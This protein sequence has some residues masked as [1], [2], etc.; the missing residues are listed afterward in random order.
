MKQLLKK[1][2]ALSL[3]MM[4][5]ACNQAT[6]MTTTTETTSSDS[7][8]YKIGTNFELTGSLGDYGTAEQRG[9]EL[10]VK[11]ANEKAG[12]EKFQLVSYDNKSDQTES[13]TI[14]TQ[15][16]SSDVVGVVGPASSL[17]SAVTYPILNSA[18]KIVVSPSAT[19][20]N[21]TR[22]NPSDPT[23]PVYPY[24]FRISFEDS[25]QGAAMAQYAVDT[26]GVKKAVVL[27]DTSLDY[28]KGLSES[29]RTQ[30]TKLGGE[31]VSTQ[32]FVSGDTDFSSILT[33]IKSQSY[34]TLFIA[35]YYTEAALIIKQAREMGIDAVIL[36]GDGFDSE[37]LVNL[38]GS[39]NL[40]KVY[41][42]TAYTT[43]DASEKL[44]SFIQAYK[45]AYHEEPGM[46]AALAY[47]SANLLIE[48][49]TTTNSTDA[50]VL[51]E[52]LEKISFSG[53]TGD[54][55]FDETHTPIKTVLVV[56]LVDGVQS[57]V[58]SVI[59]Q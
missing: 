39:Q 7:V 9:V 59:P 13:V 53:I 33:T 4:L 42:T 12:Y 18:Q 45:D 16:A 22:E 20:N 31:V 25:Y 3:A 30:L 6:K 54:F 48:A 52:T 14:S 10:A 26:L 36:G 32:Y 1:G 27:E 11:Q 24:T 47:D 55:T 35:G 43:V 58:V 44:Q 21:V 34:D 46:F 40:N 41:Y 5:V 23:S 15:L 29:F 56:E 28:A 51:Q 49:I 2:T 37:T 38:A 17:A 50:A 57:S 19:Q 8:V